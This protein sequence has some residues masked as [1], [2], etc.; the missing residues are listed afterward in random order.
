MKTLLWTL[1]L[2]VGFGVM[3]GAHYGF[4]RVTEPTLWTESWMYVGGEAG[5]EAEDLDVTRARVREVDFSSGAA[6]F[7]REIE[8]GDPGAARPF[9]RALRRHV[10]FYPPLREDFTEAHLAS[11]RLPEPGADEALA[12]YAQADA[13]TV[14]VAGRTLR[15]VGTLRREVGLFSRAYLV[16]GDSAAASLFNPDDEG[17]RHAYIFTMAY[18]EARKGDVADR[19]KA[20]FPKGTFETVTPATP[21][22]RLAYWL[23]LAGTAMLYLGGSVLFMR[24]YWHLGWR[25]RNRA[26]GRPLRAMLRYRGL[27]WTLHVAAF[28]LILLGGAVAWL[29]PV[30]QDFLLDALTTAIRS[31]EGPLGLAGKAYGSG[32][33]PRAALVTFGVNFLFG[34]V[35]SI[36]LPSLIA[37]G[38]GVLMLL[39]RPLIVGIALA[40]TMAE[41]SRPMLP[42]AFT[43]LLEMEA[44]IVAG[45]FALLV[46]IWLFRRRAGRTILSRYGR[47]VLLNLQGNLL[48]AIILVVAAVYEAIEVIAMMTKAAGG[49]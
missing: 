12:G 21:V 1:L 35:V 24:L 42:H 11:G 49:S 29:V 7:L 20:A 45:F 31:G 25:V 32:S 44:Y 27:L 36:T 39:F 15:I 3:L 47:A 40:P 38:V 9:R 18:R 46:P 26:L 14:T 16:P 30:T 4:M 23:Y 48:V 17:V 2:L 6:K 8:Q 28:G 33:V 19:L 43:I 10:I 5:P 13:E 37:P 41:L 34:S 22:P